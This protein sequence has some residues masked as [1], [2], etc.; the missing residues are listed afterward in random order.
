MTAR[1]RI[2][3]RD[4][5]GTSPR[6]RNRSEREHELDPLSELPEKL[7]PA[8]RRA[9][10]KFGAYADDEILEKLSPAE[11]REVVLRTYMPNNR[12][13]QEREGGYFRRQ[14]ARLY[15][16]AEVLEVVCDRADLIRSELEEIELLVDSGS[17]RRRSAAA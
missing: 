10:E 8:E 5:K 11:F 15:K 17:S 9:V 2:T 13:P 12:E 14:A 4:R 6:G 16:L 3:R 7:T 1:E